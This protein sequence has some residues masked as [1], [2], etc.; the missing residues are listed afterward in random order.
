MGF[1]FF[2]KTDNFISLCYYGIK[3]CL[4]TVIF[5]FL[6]KLKSAMNYYFKI[7]LSFSFLMFNEIYN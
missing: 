1:F 7:D 6:S 5:N 4:K 2:N 3:N